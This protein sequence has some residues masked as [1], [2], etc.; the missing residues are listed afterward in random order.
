MAEAKDMIEFK[1]LDY[2]SIGDD[3]VSFKLEDGAIVKVK[4][5]LERVGVATN[6]KNPDGTAHY[7][8]SSAVKV[9]VIPADKRFSLSKSQL[10]GSGTVGQLQERPSPS[11]IT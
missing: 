9:Y 8:V 6:Y 7:A 4:V 10:F 5:S 11:H 1:M 2:E 3:T